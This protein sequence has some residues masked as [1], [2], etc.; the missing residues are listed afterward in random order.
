LND[1]YYHWQGG[2]LILS[3]HLQPKASRN[4]IIDVQDNQLKVRL[5]ALPI[6]GK[7]TYRSVQIHRQKLYCREQPS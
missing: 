7:A 5:T 4:E 6:D 1:H 3:V 2:D